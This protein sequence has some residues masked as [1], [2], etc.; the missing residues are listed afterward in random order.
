VCAKDVLQNSCAVTHRSLIFE[1]H[2]QELEVY[3]VKNKGLPRLFL[4][5]CGQM[6]YDDIENSLYYKKVEE[7]SNRIKYNTLEIL[8]TPIK[9]SEP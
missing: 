7:F 6:T 4:A 1:V 3:F 9:M 2:F 8:K 5:Q